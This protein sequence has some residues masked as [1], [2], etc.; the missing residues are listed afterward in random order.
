MTL[1]I[2]LTVV[3]VWQNQDSLGCLSCFI[4]NDVCKSMK[5]MAL[6]RCCTFY[7]FCILFQFENVEVEIEDLAVRVPGGLI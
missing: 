5:D 1:Q 4:V 2:N 6:Q 3:K 7:L